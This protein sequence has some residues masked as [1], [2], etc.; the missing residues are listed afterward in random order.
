[1]DNASR[2]RSPAAPQRGRFSRWPVLGGPRCG[3]TVAYER[4]WARGP[5]K[6][7]CGWRGD[8]EWKPRLPR[9]HGT[10]R[11]PRPVLPPRVRSL[12]AGVVPEP[13]RARPSTPFFNRVFSDSAARSRRKR[14][15]GGKRWQHCIRRDARAVFSFWSHEGIRERLLTRATLLGVT[16]DTMYHSS[17]AAMLELA[18]ARHPRRPR[19]IRTTGCRRFVGVTAGGWPWRPSLHYLGRRSSESRCC[20]SPCARDFKSLAAGASPGLFSPRA[21]AVGTPAF[22]IGDWAPTRLSVAHG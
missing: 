14:L 6:A 16:R 19:A 11:S 18:A 21:T 8:A 10:W 4:P 20:S 3:C 9:R 13:R 1:M 22:E 12:R 2:G 7:L 15:H 5:P 17:L